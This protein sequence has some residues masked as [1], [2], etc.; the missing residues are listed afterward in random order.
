MSGYDLSLTLMNISVFLRQGRKRGS[1]RFPCL[2]PTRV[3]QWR[4]HLFPL[5]SI[6]VNRSFNNLIPNYSCSSFNDCPQDYYAQL[7]KKVMLI[8]SRGDTFNMCTRLS[9]IHVYVHHPH[10]NVDFFL[11]SPNVSILRSN[12]VM[13][14]ATT[15]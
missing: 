13:F 9:Q 7:I 3:H 15:K 5:P 4:H 14:V 1:F 10:V 11:S 8:F 12:K 6:I 2:T